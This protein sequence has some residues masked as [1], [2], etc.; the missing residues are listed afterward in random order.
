MSDHSSF[1]E[2]NNTAGALQSAFELKDSNIILELQ[3]GFVTGNDSLDLPGSKVS[4]FWGENSFDTKSNSQLATKIHRDLIVQ[5]GQLV[6]ARKTY[7]SN[8]P[9]LRKD[10]SSFDSE[11][12]S[13][14]AADISADILEALKNFLTANYSYPIPKLILGPMPI[15]GI[16]IEI[17]ANETSAIYFTVPNDAAK[18]EVDVK[19]DDFFIDFEVTPNNVQA[20]LVSE[21]DSISR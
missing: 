9:N 15:G 7:L 11:A 4:S 16:I 17:H 5:F 21:I 12:P 8:L 13:T 19:K 18:V 14:K 1:A 10:W 20:L 3:P 6:D 2:F